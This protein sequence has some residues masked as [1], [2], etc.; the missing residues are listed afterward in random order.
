MLALIIV[1]LALMQKLAHLAK[2]NI[3]LI[4]SQLI[5]HQDLQHIVQLVHQIALNAQ[6]TIR[7]EKKLALLVQRL[8]III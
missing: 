2:L 8:R 3:S 7:T 6:S 5:I 4:L 1:I